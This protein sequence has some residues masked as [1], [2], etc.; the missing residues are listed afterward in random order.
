MNK[1]MQI[2]DIMD[3]YIFLMDELIRFEQDKLKAVENK[4]IEHLDSFL[5]A[6]QAYLLQLR[7]LDSKRETVM[8]AQG[9]EGM[10]YRQIIN[11]IDTS[12]A[13]LR[14]ELE[15]SYEELSVKTSQFQEI[16]QTLKTHIDL[17]LHTIEAFMNKFAGQPT[18]SA[19]LG[20]Y[21][22]IAHQ[23]GDSS[24]ASRFKPTKA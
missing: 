12:E 18:E 4:E 8:K 21:D 16:I 3:D 5:K 11:S 24:S 13:E 19:Q 15:S 7:G 9:M 14:S 2:K 20:I 6:E 1:Y 23:R 17:R 10:T 22:K